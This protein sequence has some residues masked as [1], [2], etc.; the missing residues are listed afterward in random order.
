MY[1]CMYTAVVVVDI[2][3]YDHM[4]CMSQS[5]KRAGCSPLTPVYVYIYTG[6][7][8]G[9]GNFVQDRGWMALAAA[10]CMTQTEEIYKIK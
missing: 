5:Q 8:V 9:V 1:E 6:N 2:Y 4:T 3:M 10:C 7:N